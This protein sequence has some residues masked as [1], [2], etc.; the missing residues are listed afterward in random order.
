MKYTFITTVICIVL[1]MYFAPVIGQTVE[2]KQDS[3]STEL[4]QLKEQLEKLKAEQELKL[5]ELEKLITDITVKMEKAEQEDELQKL[6]EEAKQLESVER[7][8]ETGIG[9]RFHT[10]VRV[11]QRLN[12]NISVSGDFFGAFS[13]SKGDFVSEPSDMSYGNN[14]FKMREI[15]LQLNAPLDPFTRGK[16]F[17]SVS[18]EE[19]AIEEAYME[20][21]N[22]PMNMNLKAGIFYAEF[23]ALNRWH[24]HALPQFDRPKALVDFF[25]N[26]GLSGFGISSNFMLPQLL[27]ADANML[28]IAI[29]N[30][31][32][33]FSFTDTGKDRL[34]YVG[35]FNNYYDVS[36]DAY[37]EWAVSGAAGKN[38]PAEKYNSYVGSFNITYKWVPV[39]RSKYRTVDWRTEF[40]FGHREGPTKNINSKG[41]YTSLQNKLNAKYWLSGRIGYSELPYDNTQ[42][43]WDFTACLDY[44]QSEFVFIR[45]Q[46]QYNLRNFDDNVIVGYPG[47]YPNDSSFL[48]HF[49]WAMGPHKHEAY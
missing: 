3:S 5:Q 46:Y 36:R 35:H 21:L 26:G 43:E 4:Q 45:F 44:W 23:G 15:E 11:Q 47:S 24:D 22:L 27:F 16:T 39:G 28:D 2:S 10:G 12:P 38:D 40:L 18:K 25:S 49:C 32:N 41:F 19:I 37:I 34:I 13:T 31:G 29:I 17:I 14:G 20:W 7:T 33:G 42:S 9:K 8:E 48:I 1:I 30:G 6:L